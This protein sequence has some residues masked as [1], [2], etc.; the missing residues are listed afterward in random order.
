MRPIHFVLAAQYNEPRSGEAHIAECCSQRYE[1]DKV[2]IDWSVLGPPAA[3]ATSVSALAPVA[4][5]AIAAPATAAAPTPAASASAKPANAAD[6][7][8]DSDMA[9]VTHD[10]SDVN[11]ALYGRKLPYTLAAVSVYMRENM[12]MCFQK[13][14]HSLSA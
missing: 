9:V 3:P 6:M 7:P 1:G 13:M 10:I 8:G 4:T 12:H 2:S 5:P 11:K 14:L